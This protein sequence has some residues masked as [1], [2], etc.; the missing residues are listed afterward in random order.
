MKINQN[1]TENQVRIKNVFKTAKIL[2]EEEREK[3]HTCKPINENKV[4][5]GRYYY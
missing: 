5:I 4:E 3:L 1:F 2:K